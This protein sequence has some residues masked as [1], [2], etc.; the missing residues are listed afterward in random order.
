MLPHAPDLPFTSGMNCPLVRQFILIALIKPDSFIYHA[1]LLFIIY[2]FCG[3][4]K[5]YIQVT[6]S[7]WNTVGQVS[8]LV[9]KIHG[10]FFSRSIDNVW[11]LSKV[12]DEEMPPSHNTEDQP[13]KPE[14][15]LGTLAK[16]PAELRR[17]IWQYVTIG[18]PDHTQSRD[19][20]PPPYSNQLSIL[21]TSKAIYYEACHELYNHDL[22]FVISSADFTGS[23]N[24][25]WGIKGIPGVILA[26]LS[27]PVFSRFR[28]V[29]FEIGAP[30]PDT[31]RT[32]SSIQVW[33][34]C[35]ALFNTF[36]FMQKDFLKEVIVVFLNKGHKVWGRY[37]GTYNSSF[38][39]RN[40][41]IVLYRGSLAM[42]V[43]VVLN[44][45][46]LFERY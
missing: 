37:D 30:D 15:P 41:D 45:L 32:C 29:K 8:I 7:I 26:D 16:L 6:F 40:A 44:M 31:T 39:F 9:W 18:I 11:L 43:G 23:K 17:L 19:S 34:M 13:C 36:A 35:S 33:H 2:H 46:I 25:K 28:R 20:P 4:W 1:G 5:T 21:R 14:K 27:K 42:K 12:T 22:C 3:V 38:P 24:L 10:E